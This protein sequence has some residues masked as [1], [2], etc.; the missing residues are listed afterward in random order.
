MRLAVLIALPVCLLTATP[1]FRVVDLGGLGGPSAATAVNSSGVAAGW[2]LTPS[3][4]VR[5]IES[6]G[7]RGAHAID[8]PHQGGAYGIN[9]G[10]DAVGIRF[11]NFGNA[12][13][14][15]WHGDETVV[16]LGHEGSYAMAINT[17]GMVA[18]GGR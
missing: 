15:L 16:T 18:G 5:A 11:D 2:S 4:T 12:E 8:G 17:G 3:Q 1:T 14:V 7:A 6:A 9:D 10:G 13:A